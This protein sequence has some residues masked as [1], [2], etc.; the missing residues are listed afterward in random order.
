MRLHDYI[1]QQDFQEDIYNLLEFA[2]FL[3]DFERLDEGAADTIDDI[4]DKAE[5]IFMSIGF[6]T[7]QGKGLVQ[8]LWTI[9]KNLLS[10]L[11]WGTV[12]STGSEKEKVESQAKIREIVNSVSRED[13]V[14]FLYKLDSLSLG[15]I[16]TPLKMIDAITGWHIA[17]EVS[18]RI[19]PAIEK[20]KKAIEWL[21]QAEQNLEGKLRTQVQK[22]ANALRRVFGFGDFRNITA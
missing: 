15:L 7:S 20:A 21:E 4:K 12:Y 5:K 10:L 13:V 17:G 8:Y 16:S 6:H 1:E 22:Y 11:Y 19:T 3:E 2:I 9:N 18:S 14:N